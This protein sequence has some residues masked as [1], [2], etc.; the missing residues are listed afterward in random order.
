MEVPQVLTVFLLH[1]M[2]KQPPYFPYAVRNLPAKPMICAPHPPFLKLHMEDLPS[3][4]MESLFV[5]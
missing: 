5:F 1:P 2:G 3:N 4:A